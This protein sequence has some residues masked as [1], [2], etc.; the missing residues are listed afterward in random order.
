MY[1]VRDTRRPDSN[2]ALS[3]AAII[4]D[5]MVTDHIFGAKKNDVR[6]RAGHIPDQLPF[7]NPRYSDFS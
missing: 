3:T 5:G 1:Q 4:L 6:D 7:K 2:A